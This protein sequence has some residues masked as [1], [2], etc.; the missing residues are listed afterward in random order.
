MKSK[1]VLLSIGLTVGVTLIGAGTLWFSRPYTFNGSVIEPPIAAAD[2]RLRDQNDRPFR[3]SDQ[4]GKIVLMFF[5]YTSCPDACPATLAQFRQVRAD[6]GREAD[7]VRFVLV[8]V[9]PERDTAE[10]LREYLAGFDPAFIGL[11]GSPADMESVWQSYGVYREKRLLE[12]ASQAGGH[13]HAGENYTVDHPTRIYA[14]DTRGNLR[15]TY[16]AEARAAEIARDVQHLLR[17]G[18]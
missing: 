10:R 7:R 16:S 17:G 3:L 15:L 11:T 2:F 5:G 6:L 4:G 14:V 9:D 12:A 8:T 18:N 1:F 13:G